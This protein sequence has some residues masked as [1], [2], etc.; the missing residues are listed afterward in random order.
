MPYILRFNIGHHGHDNIFSRYD[1]YS[2]GLYF[3]HYLQLD[4][5]YICEISGIISYFNTYNINEYWY[6]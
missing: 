3:P 2:T 6:L 5:G 4:R 1:N